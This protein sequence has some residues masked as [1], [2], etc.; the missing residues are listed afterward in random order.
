[1]ALYWG[2]GE[3][4]TCWLDLHALTGRRH[5][6]FSRSMFMLQLNYIVVVTISERLRWRNW[7]LLSLAAAH[8]PF[9]SSTLLTPRTSCSE[10]LACWRRPLTAAAAYD[11]GNVTRQELIPCFPLASFTSILGRVWQLLLL[12]R[13]FT[14]STLSFFPCLRE[15]D[16]LLEFSVVHG[17][18]MHLYMFGTKDSS[19]CWI[20]ECVWDTL[21]HQFVDIEGCMPLI[22]E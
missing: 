7:R 6:Q 4:N 15:T 1:M 18:C 8:L 16:Y 10:N 17:K 19:S 12:Q 13:I 21:C 9:P 11:D 14:F 5:Q 22:L 20:T 3:S 2:G